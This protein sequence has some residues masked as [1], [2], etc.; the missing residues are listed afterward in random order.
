[1]RVNMEYDHA[2]QEMVA[3]VLSM[4]KLSEQAEKKAMQSIAKE[5][6]KNVKEVLPRSD[7]DG[8]HMADDVKS[9]VKQADGSYYCSVHGG[10]ETGYKWHMLDDG[11]RNPDGSVHTPAIHF[12]D[13]A[14]AKS[15]PKVE[16]ILDD[17][18][19]E[20]ANDN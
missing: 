7:S 19:K 8:K 20:I 11:T 5:I 1:M 16:K 9:T 12:T 13:S 15:T 10:K 3:E 4:P 17:L 2:L 6:V 14:M 18:V